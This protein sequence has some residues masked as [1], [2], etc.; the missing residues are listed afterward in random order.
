[1]KISRED[2]DPIGN[3]L[4]RVADRPVSGDAAALVFHATQGQA[5]EA[6]V[7]D[8]SVEAD[9]TVNWRIVAITERQMIECT[10]KTSDVGAVTDPQATLR[11]RSDLRSAALKNVEIVGGFSELETSATWVFEF[12]HGAPLTLTTHGVTST[13]ARADIEKAAAALLADL[14]R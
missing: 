4:R 6:L 11:R 5:I 12:A 3:Q 7:V 1:M 2:I 10:A 14:D 9:G 13:A 8:A